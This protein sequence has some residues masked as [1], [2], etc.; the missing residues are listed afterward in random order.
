MTRVISRSC[1][2]TYWVSWNVNCASSGVRTSGSYSPISGPLVGQGPGLDGVQD[3]EQ[4][5]ALQLQ[6]DPRRQR[7]AAP[8]GLAQEHDPVL[9]L[10]ID[11]RIRPLA[12]L[13]PRLLA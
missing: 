5:L 1:G 11:V 7:R 6:F 8:G 12:R 3:L 10:G 13:L 9:R 4:G 2:T